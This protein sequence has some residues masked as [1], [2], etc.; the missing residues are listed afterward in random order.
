M[1]AFIAEMANRGFPLSHAQLK[2]HIDSI[3]KAHLGDKFPLADVGQNWTYHFA[4]QNVEKIKI[5]YSCPLEDKCGHATNPHMNDAWWKLVGKT[6]EK[7]DVKLHNI[8]GTNEVGIQAQGDGKH[9]YIFGAKKRLLLINSM[10]ELE[11]IL[12][13]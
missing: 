12:L 11:T 6:I 3:C 5:T 2:E 9:K 8:Y 1:I 4:Q 13:L 7:Y 10:L